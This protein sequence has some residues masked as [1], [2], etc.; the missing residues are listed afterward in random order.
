LSPPRI[1]PRMEGRGKHRG[2][3]I[4]RNPGKGSNQK[5]E[6]RSKSRYRGGRAWLKRQRRFITAGRLKKEKN[7]W[8]TGHGG[9]VLLKTGRG[10]CNE[11]GDVRQNAT[12]GP[13]GDK[14]WGKRL[15]KRWGKI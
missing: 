14:T 3:V 1:R 11:L 7:R 10:T 12:T 4:F 15:S 8:E 9:R 13:R 5:K 6:K 2:V